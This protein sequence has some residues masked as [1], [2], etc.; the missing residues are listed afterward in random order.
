M[1]QPAKKKTR[2]PSGWEE[3]A[4]VKSIKEHIGAH[5]ARRRLRPRVTASIPL[6]YWDR[7]VEFATSSAKY[8]KSPKNVE[9]SIGRRL[10]LDEGL[11]NRWKHRK[12][13]PDG[14][15]VLSAL[16]V[17]LRSELDEVGFP[18]RSRIVWEAVKRTLERTFIKDYLPHMQELRLAGCS[19]RTPDVDAAGNRIGPKLTTEDYIFI[20]T[21]SSSPHAIAALALSGEEAPKNLPDGVKQLL[22]QFISERKGDVRA[23][24]VARAAALRRDFFRVVSTWAVPYALFRVGLSQGWDGRGLPDGEKHWE[25]LDAEAI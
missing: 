12:V 4:V 23:V 14:D 15:K 10:G 2:T 1:P 7:L 25:H 3:K 19:V 13:S 8:G 17:V 18:D 9:Q 24:S 21:F 20:R 5:Y 22:A 11:L 6:A 16:V